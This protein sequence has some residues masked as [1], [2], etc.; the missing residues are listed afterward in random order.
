MSLSAT[1][2]RIDPA[3]VTGTR[4][5]LQLFA[6]L[7]VAGGLAMLPGRAMAATSTCSTTSGASMTLGNVTVQASAPVGTL[8]GTATS[9]TVTFRCTNIPTGDP[10]RNLYIQA[11]NLAARSA[12]DTG[13]DGIIFATTIPGIGLKLTATPDEASASACLRCGPN[14]TPGFEIGPVPRNSGTF[15]ETFTAQLIKTGAV[16]PGT[17]SGI[18]LM[19][20]YW[21]EYGTTASSGPMATALT[22]NGG[23]TATP[24]GC[25][26][27]TGSQNLTVTLPKVSTSSLPSQGATS[28]RTRFNLNLTC[29]AGT[30]ASISFATS[31]AFSVPNGVIA[32]TT[33]TGMAAGIGIQLINGASTAPVPFNSALSLGAT[34]NGAWAVPFHV[35]YYRT[36]TTM[37][38]GTVRGTLTFTMTYP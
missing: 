22:V 35:Q 3:P 37:T 30:N 24:V 34:P 2:A 33:G 28:G 16:T 5:V 6:A 4:R 15:A 26:V 38:A 8:L 17:L 36:A 19:Q 13:S 11:G 14:S 18:Q 29:Q 9:V 25:T 27:D 21:Y 23:A 20:F 12:S 7:V 32:P 10:G 31:N 1:N